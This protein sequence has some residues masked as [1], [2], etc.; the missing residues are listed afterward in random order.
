MTVLALL[1]LLA[2]PGGEPVT[3]EVL[4]DFADLVL[5]GSVHLG[6]GHGWEELA[7]LVD[8]DLVRGTVPVEQATAYVGPDTVQLEAARLTAG[9]VDAH[10][11]PL[12]LGTRLATLDLTGAA[13]LAETLE[14]VRAAAD[15]EGWLVG[16]GWDQND[17]PD[18]PEGGWPSAV[19]LDEVVP[20]RPVAL[21][22]ID[23]HAMW[24]NSAGLKEAG[25]TA[26]TPHPE[27]GR[28][29][30]AGGQPTGILVDNAMGLV[31][32]PGIDAAEARRRVESAL[33]A[34]A[35][36]GLTGAHAM[37]ASDREVALYKALDAEGALP[38]RLWVYVDPDTEAAA[39]LLATGPVRGERLSFPGI[40]AYADGA[41]GSRGALLS[42]DYTDEPGTRGLAVRS[43]EELAD[44]ASR[45]QSGGVQLAVHAIGDAGVRSALDAWAAGLRSHP[46]AAGDRFR[47]EHAQVVDPADV[48]RFKE[49]GAVASMQPTHCTSDM[50]WAGARL[51]PEREA[52]A[53]AW[54]SFREAEVTLA[55]GSDFPIEDIDP[56]LG[57]WAATTRTDLDGQPEGG[58]HPEQ[59]LSLEEAVDA[60][61]WGAA[62][63]VGEERRLGQIARGKKADLTL[64]EVEESGRMRAVATVVGGEVRAFVT[65]QRDERQ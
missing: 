26:A 32:R 49:L 23:G 40:K 39:Q 43:Q 19:L 27:G 11:H 33:E 63:A 42:Q 13:S 14:R 8:E 41:L 53:Y 62:S 9:F 25:I 7:V 3:P 4:P 12:G 18:A 59:A 52:W 1:G 65:P 15:G 61:T 16:R 5:T 58:W 6:P 28:I 38:V 22:R 50:A 10:G 17:W 35:G 60:F 29:H 51:G 44:L 47:V 64:W 45:C 34:L 30:Q 31:E 48:P 21:T 46:Q 2:C 56:G 20:D 24:L 37:G 54:H 36:V 55:F 57:L